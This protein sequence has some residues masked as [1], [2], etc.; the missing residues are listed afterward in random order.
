MRRIAHIVNPVI[1]APSS[2]LFVAQPITFETMKLAA[3]L[4][5]GQVE[6][7]F[8]SAQYSE[9]RALVPKDFQ[10]TPDLERSVLD[11]GDF[12]KQRKLPLLA[13]ILDRLYEASN[14]EYFIFTNVD[15][16]VM[17]HFY[18]AVSA[19]IAAGVD[20]FVIN[21]RTITRK[22]TEAS[23]IALMYAEIG[24]PHEGHD[25]FVFRRE[26]YPQYRL[27]AVCT[28]VWYVGRVLLWNLAGH[29]R[30]FREYKNKHLTFH[31]GNDRAFVKEENFAFFAHN[32]KEALQIQDKLQ[33]EGD[34]AR[35]A[36]IFLR[37]PIVDF[38]TVAN[39]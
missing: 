12:P 24:E 23:Q 39:E 7:E 8:F 26:V 37:Y 5:R 9:D 22:H 28:G 15:I 27:G 32:K 29:A 34:A 19:F 13:D 14:A 38:E 20:A 33:Q 21:R 36:E 11:C 2:D 35:W 1:V 25:C 30:K 17:P 16:A 6:V 10:L 31:L 4:V 3:G 18:A